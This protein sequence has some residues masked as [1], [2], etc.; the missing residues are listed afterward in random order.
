MTVGL[1]IP[2][3]VNQ[4]Y[5]QA[6]IATLQ[7]LQKLGVEVVYPPRQTCCGQP[8]ANSGF[9]HLTQDCN[10]LFLEN[11][12]E[13]DY[14]VAPSASCVLHVKQHLHAPTNPALAERTR[15]RVYELV[16]FLTDVLKVENLAAR[17][18]HKVG[19]HQ[20]CHGLRGLYLA[21]MS[22]L[23]ASPFS[24]PVQ[25]L[26]MVDGLELVDLDR[27]D[28][29]CGFGG[30][31]CV[32][33]EAVSVKMGKDRVTDHVKNGAEYITSVDLSCLMHLEGIL[34]RNKSAIKAV[35]IAEILNA[36]V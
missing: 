24:K 1:F 16:E 7:L 4:F 6:A 9:E 13:F 30:T 20:S 32:A 18:P 8:M 21:Q 28:E 26:N 12:S 34:H 29:C 31:F 3:Y 15:S 25:L 23:N 33:E 27:P 17:F 2:C 22:E 19:I 10:R 5:P 14:I 11:F 35:H 36:T